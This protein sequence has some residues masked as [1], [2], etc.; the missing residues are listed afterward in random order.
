MNVCLIVVLALV[1]CGMAHAQTTCA[2]GRI[3]LTSL[4]TLTYTSSGSLYTIGFCYAVNTPRTAMTQCSNTGFV[5][6]HNTANTA[7]LASYNQIVTSLTSDTTG[8][9]FVV[10]DTT[11][12]QRANVSIRCDRTGTAGTANLLSVA[13]AASGAVTTTTITLQSIAGCAI[14]SFFCSDTVACSDP[15]KSCIQG[16]CF[17]PSCAVIS[18]VNST[19]TRPAN[20]LG[21]ISVQ[22]C[23]GTPL[24]NLSNTSFSVTLDGQDLSSVALRDEVAH[25]VD[26]AP[27]T[28]VPLLTTLLLDQSRSVQNNGQSVLRE[29]ARTFVNI[30]AGNVNHY[31]AVIAFA[32]SATPTTVLPHT[33]DR[34]AILAAINTGLPPTSLADADSTDLYNAV[35][36]GL[37]EA[38]RM[39][40]SFGNTSSSIISSMVVFTDGYDTARRTTSTAAI[41]KAN[42]M[43]SK[44]QIMAVGIDNSSDTNFLSAIA[45]S[46]FY[47]FVSLSNLVQTF[48]DAAQRLVALT[49]NNYYVLV[50]IP[51]RGPAVP[52]TVRLNQTRFPS[53]NTLTYTINATSFTGGCSRAM[54]QAEVKAAPSTASA[55]LERLALGGTLTKTIQPGAAFFFYFQFTTSRTITITPP[56]TTVLYVANQR[57]RLSAYCTDGNFTSSFVAAA[58]VRYDAMVRISSAMTTATT[59]ALFTTVSTPAPVIIIA[60][61]VTSTF[62]PVNLSALSD[63]AGPGDVDEP[64]AIVFFVFGMLFFV[65]FFAAA[66]YVRNSQMKAIEKAAKKRRST[67]RGIEMEQK[68]LHAPVYTAPQPY[69]SGYSP[70]RNQSGFY[71]SRASPF[72]SRSPAPSHADMSYY[73]PPQSIDGETTLHNTAS[74]LP[75]LDMTPRRAVGSMH[76]ASPYNRTPQFSHHEL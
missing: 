34:A 40:F 64:A 38:Y 48:S 46:G 15:T 68:L 6:I 27:E 55:S 17:D 14:D 4:A 56:G 19:V 25:V 67:N 9:Y 18:T 54:L 7:C 23:H 28:P 63:D 10:S 44:V 60:P 33:N 45:T 75:P 70:M 59:I 58:G 29:A 39:T 21:E 62:S 65:G 49:T 37:D 47:E 11:G 36:D 50:C 16:V 71:E 42:A 57:C 8:A 69:R 13:S 51:M 43:S 35:I 32:G 3:S 76:S 53:S 26:T 1:A 30:V 72:I 20:F 31:V 61:G 5:Q 12:N 52:L 22:D 2:V 74:G 41:V 66:W 24:A 73:I